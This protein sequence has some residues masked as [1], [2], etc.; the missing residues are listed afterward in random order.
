M[1]NFRAGF[2][3]SVVV[4]CSPEFVRGHRQLIKSIAVKTGLPVMHETNDEGNSL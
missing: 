4:S 1:C 3:T 2:G